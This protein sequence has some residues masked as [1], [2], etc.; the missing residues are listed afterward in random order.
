MRARRI[1]VD[2][3]V[4][5]KDFL[6]IQMAGNQGVTVAQNLPPKWTP[7]FPP[8]VVIGGDGGGVDEWPAYTGDQVRVTVYAAGR[9]EARRIAG[10]CMGW[11]LALRVP[12]IGV[13][14]GT[15]LL[16]D[17]D[18]STGGFIAG[19]TVRTRA[20]TQSF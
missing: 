3:V 6:A 16:D 13:R 15:G 8:A 18:P 1:P 7:D 12:G 2:H 14:P 10:L 11:L 20:R 4:P 17:R 5:V 9:T 19:F